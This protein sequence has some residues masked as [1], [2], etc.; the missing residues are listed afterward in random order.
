MGPIVSSSLRVGQ[1]EADREALLLFQLDEPAEVGELAVVEVRFPEPALDAGGD[2][3]G[4]LGGAVGGGERLGPGGQ[5]L[6]RLAPD[7]LARLDDDDGRARAG[8]DGLGHRPEEVGGDVAR[9]RRRGSAH[10]HEVG[11]IGLAED[12]VADIGGLA[13]D[14]LHARRGVLANQGRQGPLGLGADGDRDPGRDDMEG[15]ELRVVAAR[16][17]VCKAQGKLG[18]GAATDGNHDPPDLAGAALLDDGDVAG[19]VADD[20]LDRRR[21]GRTGPLAVAGRLAA[22]AEDDQVGVQLRGRFDDPLGRVA[23]DPDNRVDGRP[24]GHEVE[25][26]LEESPGVA[27]T[28]RA[29][30]EGHALRHL[31]DPEGRQLTGPRIPQVGPETDELLRRR[32]VGDRDDD[33]RGKGR[34]HRLAAGVSATVSGG[35]SR[36]ASQRARR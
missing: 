30:R 31:D 27:G 26:L 9:G 29:L 21:E 14:R 22:P 8:G 24:L 16:E 17:R 1:D 11:P 35:A 36:G 13:D 25:D 12:R 6:E 4:L 10:D 28:G 2:G 7:G 3:A 19:G 5:L 15:H 32:G 34:A 20:L 18:V 33:P 23:P